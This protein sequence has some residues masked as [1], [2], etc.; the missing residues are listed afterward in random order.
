MEQLTII[1]HWCKNLQAAALVETVPSS[2]Y[3]IIPDP[4]NP[5]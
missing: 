5:S 2:N 1:A 4:N 3:L